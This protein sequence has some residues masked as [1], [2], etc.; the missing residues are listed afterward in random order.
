[1]R[2]RSRRRPMKRAALLV[3]LLSLALGLAPVFSQDRTGDGDKPAAGKKDKRDSG[4]E[5]EL[6]TDEL[7]ALLNEVDPKSPNLKPPA[8]LDGEKR[9]RFDEAVAAFTRA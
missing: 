9:Q 2:P 7:L 1:M 4:D 5:D 8:S 3:L 6:S